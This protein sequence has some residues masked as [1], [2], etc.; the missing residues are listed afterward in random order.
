[1]RLYLLELKRIL[2]TRT[3][4]LILA[5]LL[6]LSA[7]FGYLPST[8][9]YYA[10]LGPNGEKIEITGTEAI[11]LRREAQSLYEGDLTVEKMQA[12]LA[13]YQSVTAQYGDYYGEDFPYNV[14]L[15]SIFPIAP[16]LH[17][18]REAYADSKTGLAADLM[19]LTADDVAD[20][21]PTLHKHFA[22]L[23]GMEQSEYPNIQAKAIGMYGN[24]R[25]P[26]RF[27]PGF[28]TDAM[29]YVTFFLLMLA[30]GMTVLCAPIFSAE[31]QTQ[32][33][34]ILRITR[35]GQVRLAATKLAAALTILLVTF[36]LCMGILCAVSDAL[37]GREC[38]QTSMRVQY[39][40]AALENIS[41]ARMRTQIILAGFMTLLA[42]ASCTLF[43]ST[44]C[45]TTAS[46]IICALL[47]CLLP[48]ILFYLLDGNVANWV[49]CMLPSGGI[50]LGNSYQYALIDIDFLRL[51]KTGFWTPQVI[52]MA[53]IIE[54][55]LFLGLSIRSYCRHTA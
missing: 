20:F 31:Y 47:M 33:D 24:A 1:M 43:L 34:D 48:M 51:G 42:T 6:M 23:I 9:V 14:Y 53:T 27:V 50:G 52:L 13:T 19:T 49:R 21:Y 18:F 15:E 17:I 30:L 3:T 29:D 32:S 28:N 4:W 41:I 26:L 10:D 16:L 5:G 35:H 40:A 38:L 12:V 55:P 8:F 46:A 37:F 22:D 39:T 25:E 7:L 44:R 45:R 2:K 54:T 36:A 11:R